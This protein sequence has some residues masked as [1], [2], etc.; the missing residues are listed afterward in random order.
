MSDSLQ[1]VMDLLQE[2]DSSTSS[3]L[4]TAALMIHRVQYCINSMAANTNFTHPLLA[5][6]PSDHVLPSS[7]PTT[8]HPA[9]TPPES[10]PAPTL[11]SLDTP[12]TLLRPRPTCPYNFEEYRYDHHIQR[13]TGHK[14]PPLQQHLEPLST[15][16]PSCQPLGTPCSPTY[17]QLMSTYIVVSHLR[18]CLIPHPLTLLM[19]INTQQIQL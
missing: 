16:L 19:L 14:S 11:P 1:H 8:T 3:S 12:P 2:P 5:M 15:S 9:V 4:V 17:L 7:E 10:N 13:P 18:P 6:S